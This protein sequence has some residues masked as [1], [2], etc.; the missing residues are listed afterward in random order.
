MAN[1][2]SPIYLPLEFEQLLDLAMQ[3]P[4]NQ[5]RQLADLL[6]QEHISDNVPEFQKQLVRA[7]IEKYNEHP[8]LLI[9]EDR[10]LEIIKNM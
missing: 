7:R 2:A 9:E 3:L 6:L 1:T 8:D 4:H 5:R 10:A